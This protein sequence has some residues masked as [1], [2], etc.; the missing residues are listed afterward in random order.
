[1][2]TFTDFSG[3][4]YHI[5]LAL[6]KA[7]APAMHDLI[8]PSPLWAGLKQWLGSDE[9]HAMQALVQQHHPYIWDELQGLARGLELPPDDVFLWNSQGA[10]PAHR[11]GNDMQHDS[12][13]DT[14]T[15]TACSMGY[16]AVESTTLLMPTPQAPRIVHHMAGDPDVAN[17]CGVAEFIVDQGPEFAAFVSPGLLPGHAV[18]VTNSG[19]CVTVNTTLPQNCGI[20]IPSI[21]LTRALLNMPDLSRAI[22]FLND[23]PRCGGL[24][25]S[26]AQRGGSA[27]LGIETTAE[28]VSIQHSK[29]PTLHTNH[30]IHESM[31]DV[32]QTISPSSRSRLD[33]GNV[34]LDQADN[35]DPLRLLAQLVA[36][37]RH[38]N[39]PA[40][41]SE[42]AVDSVRQDIDQPDLE[43]EPQNTLPIRTMVT[44]DLH[45]NADAVD[46]DVYED[47]DEPA[48]FRMREARHI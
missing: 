14:A 48:R 39:V 30:L 11:A 9:L 7:G 35:P 32:A 12:N 13:D 26:L 18:A 47:I 43:I 5:G 10:L 38:P 28:Q 2:L 16:M 31:Q 3:S 44:A 41:H 21:V 34:R 45:I 37:T 1:M 27:L 46:W 19:L 15:T 8:K 36:D 40:E 42:L 25:L 29:G 33:A 23:S 24:H 4:P 6:G 20:G 22:Q 17:H